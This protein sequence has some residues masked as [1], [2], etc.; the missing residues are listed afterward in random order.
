[1]E[2]QTKTKPTREERELERYRKEAMTW[3]VEKLHRK[4]DQECDMMGLARQDGDL[5]DAQFRWKKIGIIKEVL[6]Y[7]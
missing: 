7:H 3:S 5:R 4:Y 2:S 6:G 1:M